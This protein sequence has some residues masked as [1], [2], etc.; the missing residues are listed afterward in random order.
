MTP[1]SENKKNQLTPKMVIAVF[2]ASA[3]FAVSFTALTRFDLPMRGRLAAV[4]VPIA[5]AAWFIMVA[6]RDVRRLDEMQQRIQLEALAT[7]YPVAVLV[8]FAF[9]LLKRAGFNVPEAGHPAVL[10][11]TVLP[12][13]IGYARAYRRYR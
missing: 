8:L 4:A 11:L 3:A 13:L 2:A 10:L 5:L 12:Y 6:V 7:A 1:I 9:G